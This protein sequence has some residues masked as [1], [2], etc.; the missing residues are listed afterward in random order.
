MTIP[1]V[2]MR[3]ITKHF[4]SLIANDQ[5]CFDIYPGEVH[6]LLG[7]NG[8]GKT[9][10]MK[11][12]YGL[13]QPD[14]GSIHIHGK[15]V[16]LRSP[17][18]AIAHGIG[19][20]TQHFSLVPTLS[21]A[22]N[23]ILGLDQEWQFNQRQAEE[24]VRSS[25][26]RYQFPVDPTVLVQRLS[27]GEQQRVE[28]LKALHR[29]CRVL[30]LDEPTA[31]LT[32]Q[33]SKALFAALRGLVTQGVSVV[34]I[35]HKLE[36]VLAIAHRITIL[37]DGRKVGQIDAAQ[38][39]HATLARLMVGRE[40]VGV[41][42]ERKRVSAETPVLKIQN[43]WALNER[44]LPALRNINLTVYPGEIV[45]LA[46][47][48]GNG[49]TELAAVL[50]GLRAPTQ[51]HLFVQGKEVTGADPFRMTGL[52]VG[53][54]PEDRLQGLIADL[55]V[56]ENIALERLDQF[57]FPDGRLNTRRMVNHALQLI[58][59][60]QIKATPFTRTGSLS[61]GNM[62]KVILAR[63]LS[64]HPKVIVAAQPTRGL[65]IGAT[66]YVHEQLLAQR[67]QGVGILLI[68]ED[69]DEILTLS[70]RIAVIYEGQIV[71]EL[72]AEEAD[73]EHIGLLMA[74]IRRG[75]HVRTE[76]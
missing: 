57:T 49:Q 27:V 7:E 63:V 35:S 13:Y 51:G 4:G 73:A 10:L 68:S 69:L 62:Q 53:R 23:I 20:V 66:Q 17:A 44:R 8:A 75:N 50:S 48:S 34:F 11:I 76:T 71:E 42:R 29:D 39:S 22:E 55:S 5:I 52:G 67:E 26:E 33:E 30:I 65:D 40:V 61:G 16:Q 36:E 37:R 54:I 43:L 19:M 74:G 64:Q 32:P 56:A 28:I 25:A 46:G 18:D 3:D 1:L 2:E 12:L 31:V 47:V 70:D 60:Y 45:G 14:T 15:K 59:E 6:A 9:T 58:K 38:A 41:R 24:R 21:V 72:P